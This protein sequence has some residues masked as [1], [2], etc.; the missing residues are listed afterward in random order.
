MAK[1]AAVQMAS[2]PQVQANLMEAARLIKEAADLGADMVVLPETF[3]IMGANDYEMVAVA[4][5][6]GEGSIQSFMSQ[7]A[8]NNKI[9]VVAGTIPIRSSHPDKANAASIMYDDKGVQVAR[10]DK[11]HLFD[12]EIC[13]PRETYIESDTIEAGDKYVVIDT[14]F[15]KIGMAVCYDLRFPGHFRKMMAQ[16]AEIFILPS[17]FTDTTGKAHWEPLLRARA[18]ENLCY[19]IAPA[20]GG[21]HVSGR[22]TYGHTMVVDYWGNIREELGKGAGVIMIET[23]AKA[24]KATRKAFPVLEHR[25]EVLA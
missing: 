12:V 23:D 22:A 14:P 8:K 21:Y 19:V 5:E 13:E 7:C 24:Q 1:I 6:A 10:Y 17:A 16:G 20:Q 11:M 18:I 9:W 2:G 3:A 25:L 15:G 4:E